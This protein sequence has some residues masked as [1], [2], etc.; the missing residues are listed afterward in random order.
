MPDDEVELSAVYPERVERWRPLVA[1]LLVIPYAII[2]S[3]I[4]AVAQICAIIAF[5]T[6]I[7]TRGMPDGVY[8]IMRVGLNWQ[9][10]ANFYL[11]WLSTEYPPFS[12]EDR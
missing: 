10:R 1:W 4:M 2:A 11:Y 6:I 7:F 5:F 8:A 12:W 3:L 9:T